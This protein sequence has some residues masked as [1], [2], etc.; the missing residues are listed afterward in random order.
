MN[1]EYFIA[2]RL[3][4]SKGKSFTKTIVGIAVAAIAIS[5]S[6]MLLTN[7]MIIG[8]KREIHS[9]IFGFW[10][11]IHITD[12]NVNRDFE[13]RPISISAEY[14]N[15]IKNIKSVEYQVP[16]TMWG[17]TI[18]GKYTEAV[19]LGGVQ[20]V[21]PFIIMP[22][23]IESGNDFQAIFFKGID[24]DFDWNRMNRFMVAGKKNSKAVGEEEVIISKIIAEKLQL[25][26]GKEVILSFVKGKIKVRRK[27]TVVGIFNTGLEEY[28]KRFV[29]GNMNKLRELLGWNDNQVAGIEVFLDNIEDSEIITD[30]IYNYVLPGNLYAERIQQKFPSIFEWLKLQDINEKVILQ[31]M[32]VVAVINMITVLL[33]LILERTRMVGILKSLGSNN[34]QIQKIFLVQASVIIFFGQLLGNVIGLGLAYLQKTYKFIKLDE[35]NYYLD[36]APIYIDWKM[37]LWIN[38]GAFFFVLIFLILPTFIINRIKPI[39]ALRFN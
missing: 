36:T 6:V 38:L 20:H 12:T 30:Y 25:G 35:Q 27:L 5:L 18:E 16:A 14:Y 23:L 10:G 37:V 22:G 15:Q 33:I 7:A 21:Q 8:F 4:F 2:K 29:I 1:F 13:L 3:A 39:A 19:T 34:W 28:D 26:V 24:D 11:H 17:K 32:G 31:L 9:K